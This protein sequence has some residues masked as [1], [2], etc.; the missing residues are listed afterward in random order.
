MTAGKTEKKKINECHL[1]NKYYFL[2][3]KHMYIEKGSYPYL[4]LSVL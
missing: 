3:L 4:L 1:T 2:F